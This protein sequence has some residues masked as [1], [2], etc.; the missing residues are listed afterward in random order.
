[1]GLSNLHVTAVDLDPEGGFLTV[2]VESPAAPM[3]CR[4]CGAVAHGH[5][6]RE[7]V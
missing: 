4:S 3:G 5:G 6:R 7:V 2:R 1:V